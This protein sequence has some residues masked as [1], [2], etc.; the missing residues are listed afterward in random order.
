MNQNWKNIIGSVSP[1][2]AGMLGGPLA[3][4]AVGALSQALLGKPDG[5]EDEVASVVSKASPEVLAQIK[6]T[7]AKLTIA[8]SEAGIKLE[9]I[10]ANDR[11]SARNRQVQLKDNTPTYIA[12]TFILGYMVIFICFLKIN[13]SPE[14]ISI[15]NVLI[16][17]LSSGVLGIL[18]YFFGSSSGSASKSITI[19]RA[20][21]K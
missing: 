17:I 8:L 9:E 21:N 15:I 14:K 20:L 10:S 18:N 19:D 1:A 7:E 16:G 6:E 3:A 2:L 5:S 13:I 11:D 4:T 12:W